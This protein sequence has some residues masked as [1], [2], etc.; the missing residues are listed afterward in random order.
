M[1]SNKIF[2]VYIFSILLTLNI[3]EK[4]SIPESSKFASL[5]T[6]AVKNQKKWQFMQIF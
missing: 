5:T 4:V 6:R 3:L 1:K 2:Q